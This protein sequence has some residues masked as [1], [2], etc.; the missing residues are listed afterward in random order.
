MTRLPPLR[1]VTLGVTLALAGCSFA[2][3]AKPPASPNPASYTVTPTPDVSAV[4]DGVAQHFHADARAVPAWW[5]AYGSS[6]LDAW[7][8]EGLQHSPSLEAARHTLESVRQQYRAEVGNALWPALD[9]GGQVSRQRALGFPN[10]GPPTNIYDVYAGQLQLSY[11][12]DLFGVSRNE[13]KQAAAQVDAQAYQ[14]DAARRA[15]AANIVISAVRASSLA[16]QVSATERLSALT[17]EQAGLAENAYKLGAA[18]H[19]D[20][21]DAQRNAADV[22]A[23]LPG[24][25]T[26]ALRERHALAVLLGRTPDRSPALIPL[27]SFALPGDV[28]VIVPSELLSQRPDVQ[29]ADANVRAASAQIG[30]ATGNMFPHLSLSASLGSAAFDRAKLFTGAGTIWG[31]TAGLTQPIFHDGA[32][33]AQRKAAV[34]NYEAAIAQYQ[35]TVLG[36][37]Q[38]VADT[39][40]ALDQDALALQA[41]Q[42]G[43]ASAHQ[44]HDDAQQRY[45]LGSAAYPL[46]VVSEQRW[47][48]ARV[49]TMQARAARLIDTAALFQAMGT[50]METDLGAA[51]ARGVQGAHQR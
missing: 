23:S 6:A 25:R 51:D 26:Q 50:P 32:L 35:Q 20:V 47:Q 21:L 22:D 3:P 42:S 9:A 16:E 28:P 12:F 5:K 38:N 41:A 29:A 39:L 24:L 11:D 15:L 43:E 14:F 30:V 37:F 27:A 4:A 19:E 45:R 49:Q 17:H 2:P 10:V 33:R 1:L 8:D 44:S 13:V 48:N 34:A 18:A 36:A 40:T 7:V 46:T 31:A